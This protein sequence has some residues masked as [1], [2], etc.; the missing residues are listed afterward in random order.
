MSN[1]IRLLRSYA[2]GAVPVPSDLVDG[3]LAINLTDRK[4]Y[5]KDAAGTV[6]E[7]GGSSYAPLDSPHLFGVPTAPTAAAGTDSDQISTTAFVKTA[8][9]RALAGLD[10]Q[11]DVLDVQVDGTLDPGAT[12]VT[13]ARYIVTNAA[14][15]HANF[16]SIAGLENN[17]IVEFDGS[18]F[19]VEYDVSVQ[20]EGALAWNRA[21]HVWVRWDGASWDE[22]GGLA[23]VSGGI[24]ITVDGATI[25]LDLSELTDLGEGAAVDDFVA[26][27]D[28]SDGDGSKKVSVQNLVAN[29][30]ID[31]GVYA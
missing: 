1:V 13:G 28:T 19:V 14:D 29:V 2:P 25:S 20:G 31:G 9:D 27:T 23:G 7:V 12:P 22:F 4:L 11:S 17:D 10:I 26:I 16:G 5:S 18:A 30:V 3:E 24:G 8:I 21:S 15:L 6:Y